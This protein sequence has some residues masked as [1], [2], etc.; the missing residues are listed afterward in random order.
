M[1]NTSEVCLAIISMSAI[2]YLII[3][4][5]HPFYPGQI[6]SGAEMATICLAQALKQ[7]GKCVH[8]AGILPDG[9]CEIAGIEFWDLGP[10]FNVN[11]ALQRAAQHGCYH[12]IS[13]GR[14]IPLALAAGV[15]ECVSATLICHDPSG[16]ASGINNKSLA[17]LA[18]AVICV[19]KAQKELFVKEGT[20]ADHIHVIYNGIDREIFKVTGKGTRDPNKLIFVGA[21]VPHK[22]A[23]LLIEAFNELRKSFPQ[24]TLDLY[25]SSSL[26]GSQPY[27][28]E[29]SLAQA[30]PGI[31]F[32]GKQPQHVIAEAMN[33]AA[34]LVM[35]SIWFESFPLT[36]LEAQA[37]GCPI[38]AFN[39]GGLIETMRPGQ[40]GQIINEVSAAALVRTLK[41]LLSNPAQLQQY[42]KNAAA[43]V[44]STFSWAKTAAQVVSLCDS[45]VTVQT[46]TLAQ[47]RVGLVSTWNQE[48]G[49]AIYARDFVQH[50]P[51][52][53]YKIYAEHCDK[54]TSADEDFVT[55]CWKRGVG[56]YQELESALLNSDL[57]IVHI[58]CHSADFFEQPLFSEVLARVRAAGIK[59][60]LTLHSVFTRSARLQALV[61]SVDQVLV[62]SPEVRLEVIA[63]GARP[64]QVQVLP[65]GVTVQER[66]TAEQQRSLR[67]RLGMS[68]NKKIIVSFGFV[69]PHKGIEGILAAVQHMKSNGH[70]VHAY[71][72]GKA[73]PSDPNSQAYLSQLKQASEQLGLQQEISFLDR[74]LTEAEVNDY[75]QAADLV[76]MNYHSQHFE[77]SAAC[78][79]AVGAGAVVATSIAP[80]FA[81]FGDAVWHMTS[82]Y[83]PALSAEL[84]LT[85]TELRAALLQQ[86][87]AYCEQYAWPRFSARLSEIYKAVRSS[88]V[89]S[90]SLDAV[91]ERAVNV[92]NSMNK[93]DKTTLRVLVQNRANTF[94]HR[95]GDTVVIERTVE[96]LRKLGIDVV[97]DVEGRCNPKEFD[98]VHLF[99]FA[100]PQV[101][102][103]LAENAKSSGTPFVITTLCE[104]IPTFRSQA[105]EMAGFLMD[106]VESGQNAQLYQETFPDTS[107]VTP[108]APFD[109]TFAAKHA[110]LLLT[111]GAGES[112]VLRRDYGSDLPIAEVPIAFD[113]TVPA[114]AELFEKAYGVKDFVLCVARFEFRKNQLMLLKALENSDL[115]LVLAGGGFSFDKAYNE[116]VRAFKRKG[117]TIIADR[118]TP[119]LLSS[120]Y[121]AC[122]VHALPSWC[123]LPG[124]V[125]LEA[126]SMGANVVATRC[127][128]APDYLGDR[129]F[130]CNPGDPDSILNAIVAA[131]HSPKNPE[132]VRHVQQFSW[133]ASGQKI[134]ELYK[135]ICP[136]KFAQISEPPVIKKQA[137]KENR[138][139]IT[140]DM[141]GYDMAQGTT[142]FQ[143][144]L[145]RGELA[146]R[147]KEYNIAHELLN[148]AEQLNPASVRALRARGAVYLAENQITQAQSFFERA[149]ELDRNDPKTLSGLGMCF[150]Q[151]QQ[152]RQAQECFVSALEIDCKALVTILQLIECSYIL[153]QF[154]DLVRVLRA[155]LKEQPA[156]IEMQYCL[157]GALFKQGI[158]NEADTIV[159]Q[160]LESKASHLGAQQLKQA[161]TEALQEREALMPANSARGIASQ[162]E[163][164]R[165]VVEAGPIEVD[166][167]L[168]SIEELKRKREFAGVLEQVEQLLERRDLS[169]QQRERALLVKAEALTLSNRGAEAKLIINA[170]LSSNPR[171][172]RALC[173]EGALI[174]SEGNWTEAAARF[175]Q[176]L[177]IQ[178]D[179]D[180]ALAGL[181][182]FENIQGNRENAWNYYVQAAQQNPENVR[183]IL[184]ILEL[185]YAMR[186][187]STVEKTL[188]QYLELHPGDTEFL[189][190]LAGCYYAQ[191]KLDE[192]ASEVS[193]ITLFEPQH[194]R[195][196]E[197]KQL[198]SERAQNRAQ[199]A[200]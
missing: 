132:L 64:E 17:E 42:S 7:A 134:S 102:R 149:I 182:L 97:V 123:E 39:N 114:E 85:N 145:E 142:E 91:S 41:E 73:N 138:P 49:I 191:D 171:S 14:A 141:G 98:I 107:K 106:Y 28:D 72:A 88:Q 77:A 33:S 150:M 196:N 167:S 140:L 76:M 152:P 50:L 18:D 38:V 147:N 153:N 8:V 158:L 31:T 52:G 11:N 75:L 131:Y 115:T 93:S 56:R 119:E 111:N 189:Y 65:I 48:C 188:Q 166:N 116:A 169:I 151:Q 47:P 174:A 173:T 23:H 69:Q 197:L 112:K 89:K 172:V 16:T 10:G 146:A 121:K 160:V 128:T 200:R 3:H 4:K 155:Y 94:T 127:G 159:D 161:I 176:A 29:A 43:F 110:R 22:G 113:P 125:T 2:G 122:R 79:L 163:V 82:G 180:V 1:S 96:E 58:N 143:E 12:L 164:D 19:S 105:I 175:R 40:T 9:D 71:I 99:N 21:L 66:L 67:Q 185:G 57:E 45:F 148:R 195:A 70:A 133:A 44:E 198:I 100:T 186:R 62:H 24:L 35:P 135:Q 154:D 192:A 156:D 83:P 51:A 25:G 144:I 36:S 95:G 136:Q 183:A 168:G 37:C 118:L 137:S 109:N 74:F 15:K 87:A 162:I 63:N 5:D 117:R 78:S 20:P 80:P 60:I 54:L 190:S 139:A 92:E 178:P 103:M 32:K 177:E 181:G 90:L 46:E 187:L 101:T 30:V 55:R 184:G 199:A 86:S 124:M 6:N 126:A 157:A 13:A 193:K 53:S 27:L 108:A 165:A 120:A 129:A 179:Y 59:V 34:L 170:V 84:L 81:F 26:W 130:Y 61:K 194:E 68:S 104:D